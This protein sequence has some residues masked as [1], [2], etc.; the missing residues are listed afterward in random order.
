[1]S[2]PGGLV[3]FPEAERQQQRPQKSRKD[4]LGRFPS[5]RPSA[6]EKL[7]VRMH[8]LTRIDK[9][10]G[11]SVT[12]L[13]SHHVFSPPALV[14]TQT[15]QGGEA[16]GDAWALKAIFSSGQAGLAHQPDLVNKTAWET[17]S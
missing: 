8:S 17:Q 4:A 10:P 14:R 1:M 16:A 12:V 2:A 7:K 9:D 3:G 11:D 15:T 6:L 5:C 13:D